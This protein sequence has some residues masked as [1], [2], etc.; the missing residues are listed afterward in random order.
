[1]EDGSWRYPWGYVLGVFVCMVLGYFAFVKGARVPLLSAVDLG[2][3]E[4]GHFL[5]RPFPPRVMVLMGSGTQLLVPFLLAAYFGLAQRDLLGLGL[6]L[7]WTGT[8]AQDVSVYIADAPI[9]ALPLLY[10]GESHDWHYLLS[11]SGRLDQAAT[12][13]SVVKGVGA[14]LLIGGIVSCMTGIAMPGL[15]GRLALRAEAKRAAARRDYE[16]SL[17]VHEPRNRPPSGNDGDAAR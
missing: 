11:V 15:R 14:A 1:M 5:F 10:G 6:M 3:H 7:A 17:P 2:F 12:W 16:R 4:L 9:Q 13:A 8:S